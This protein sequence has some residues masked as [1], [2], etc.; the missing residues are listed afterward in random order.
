MAEGAKVM[1]VFFAHFQV[2]SI[3]LRAVRGGSRV[4]F[5]QEGPCRIACGRYNMR[6]GYGFLG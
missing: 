3:E 4:D 5:S 6:S 2:F 1:G